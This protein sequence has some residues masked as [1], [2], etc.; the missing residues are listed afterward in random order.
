M[1]TALDRARAMGR[2][3]GRALA[4]WLTPY[5]R[6][7]AEDV[8][9]PLSGEWAGNPTPASVL[10]YFADAGFDSEDILSQYEEGYFEAY[11][12]TARSIGAWRDDD[13]DS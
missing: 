10:A 5:D 13:T 12:R 3:H 4:S 6:V 11:E 9:D 8:P 2:D 1:T 7:G